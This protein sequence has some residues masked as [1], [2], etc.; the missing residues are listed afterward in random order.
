M[1][2]NSK[3]Y[4]TLVTGLNRLT[5]NFLFLSLCQNNMFFGASAFVQDLVSWDLSSS[6]SF[7]L[8]MFQDSDMPCDVFS[9]YPPLCTNEFGCRNTGCPS[10]EPSSVPSVKPSAV[11]SSL[12]SLDPTGSRLVTP[13]TDTGGEISLEEAVNRFVSDGD[14]WAGGAIYGYVKR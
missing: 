5:N 9:F 4:I 11:A 8:D 14:N 2:S 1:D 3:P 7:R 12:P 6:G 13:F 10:A